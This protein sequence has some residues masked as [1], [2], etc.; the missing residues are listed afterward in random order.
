MTDCKNCDKAII[1][2]FGIGCIEKKDWLTYQEYKHK[3]V[4]DDCPKKEK[5]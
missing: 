4:L 1:N 2:I 5:K 3:K